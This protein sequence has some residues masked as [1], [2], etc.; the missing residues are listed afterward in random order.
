M[1]NMEFHTVRGY[2]LLDQNKRLLTS[3][4]E[5]YLEMIFRN[6]S[7]GYLRI[8]RLAELLHVKP[9][10]VTK[11][12]Q[13]LGSL[14]FLKY[15]K[16]GIIVLTENGTEIGKYLLERHNIIESFFALINAGD[17]VLEET[18]LIEHY[19]SPETMR[20]L[21]L[22][23]QFLNKNPDIRQQFENYKSYHNTNYNLSGR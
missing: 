19:L 20:N 14:G 1:D 23:I 4:M 3:A 17:H 16:Y 9:S 5:D 2:Q 7:N 11:M 8:N 10:S 6:S 15:E 13:K 18:E 22:F 12:V 21:H